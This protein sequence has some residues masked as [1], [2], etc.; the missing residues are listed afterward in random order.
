[1]DNR[2]EIPV[3]QLAANSK[4]GI[5]AY[6]Y[7]TL[8]REKFSNPT[9]FI[10]LALLA[11]GIG[12]SVY[13]AGFLPGILCIAILGA[14]PFLYSIIA[15]PQFGISILMIA[16]YLLM[17]VIKMGVGFP[18]GTL[19]DGLQAFLLVGLLLKI[20]YSPPKGIFKNPVTYLI[21]VWI[22]YNL[23]EVAN[24][25]VESR[26]SWLYTIRTVA[27]VMLMYF[28]F[29]YHIRSKQFLK[30]IV[31]L[32]LALSVFAGLYALW[33]EYI[34]FLPFE[35]AGL[36]N[37]E[38]RS[39]LLIDGRWRKFSIFADPVTFSYNMVA[40]TLLCI[41]L[42]TGN[43]S[44]RKKY[45]LGGMAL[46]FTYVMLFSGTR[47]AYVLPPV[48]LSLLAILKMSKRMF[49]G[50][51]IGAAVFLF[52]VFVPTSNYTLYRFQTAFRPSDDPSFNV[53][54]ANQKRIQP[55][56]LTHPLGGGLGSTG[57]WGQRFAPN[58]YLANF[59]PDSGYVRV[60][61]ELGWIGLFLFCTLVFTALKTGINNY[62]RIKDPEL[63]S[64]CLAMLLI[65]FALSVGNYPQEAFVQFP[66][67]IY[68]F[69]AIAIINVTMR[70]D[71]EK[72]KSITV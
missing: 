15:Y 41:G 17:W 56:I 24:P 37:P 25:A 9:G 31:K 60:A 18:I 49:I 19:M 58:S 2:V 71:D 5:K 13:R 61:V 32:W 23:A 27:M 51:L 4:T 57:A 12:Y 59:P 47:G 55:Y 8:V 35:Q 52:F 63:K 14:M 65:V 70:L 34:G 30:F 6:L 39:L 16:A 48:G 11:A 10:L 29:M 62:Y 54:K 66:T 67:N 28:V 44:K 72:Q 68:L 40:S 21:V 53:R 42:I 69:L 7:K 36:D 22:L 45:I 43:I 38:V 64:I 3:N 20:K 50:A 46:L 26:L 33:Q 1:M